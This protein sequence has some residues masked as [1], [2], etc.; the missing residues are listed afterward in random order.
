MK[1]NR[2]ISIVVLITLI[3]YFSS[4]TENTIPYDLSDSNLNLDTVTVSSIV[5][6]TFLSPPLMGSTNGIYFGNADG[7]NNIFS[8]IQFSS[9]SISGAVWTYSLLDT[10]VTI[11]SL[12]ITFTAAEDT[13]LTASE[14][15][16]FYFPEGGDSLFS[17]SESNYLNI[18]ETN[19]ANSVPVGRSTFMLESPD[20]TESVYPKLSFAI[21]N[22]DE[23]LN[24]IADTTDTQ[25]RTFMLK[26]VDTINEIVSINSR[27]SVDFP[28]INAYYRVGEDTLHSVFFSIKDLT[29]ME[30]RELTEN[31][32][33]NISVGRA[34]GLKSIIQFDLRDIPIDSSAM[35][36]K[37][38]ELIFN[39]INDLTSEDYKISAAILEDSVNISNYWEI[40]EDQYSV[41]LDLLMTGTFED[42]QLKMEIRS[43]LQGLNTG[44]YS[45]LGLK[46]YGSTDSN[47]YQSVNLI[48]DPNNLDN[49]PYLK[50][51][52]VKL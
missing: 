24:F 3:I 17:E 32:M 41:S 50:I 31:D 8:L 28:I 27:E 13:L 38:A 52:Y 9:L 1:K 43:F 26:N 36:I 11:D 51:I 16:L 30:P 15:E 33:R 10:A 22:T 49:N 44:S 18:T 39:T 34:T 4:C 19:V 5:G 7:F 2:I 37:S 47:P 20:S 35:V 14:F 40:D 48:L 42:N 46:L 21:D 12:V 29:I 25:N 23:I 6:G 45:N